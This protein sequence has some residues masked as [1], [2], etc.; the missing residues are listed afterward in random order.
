MKNRLF[1]T[2]LA[3]SMFY[4]VL[5]AGGR[6]GGIK[7]K[8]GG[9]IDINILNFSATGDGLEQSYVIPADAKSLALR[10]SV[11]VDMRKTTG[12]SGDEWVIMSA[13]PEAWNDIEQLHG[14][15]IYFTG[16]QDSTLTIRKFTTGN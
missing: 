3:V 13:L 1:L 14:D 9:T 4:M 2:I 6:Y 11:D 16:T 10:A 8:T 5:G 7:Q 15:T 12:T